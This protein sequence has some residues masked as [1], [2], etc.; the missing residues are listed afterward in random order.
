MKK[1]ISTVF[2]S[3]PE[4]EA[5]AMPSVYP[6]PQLVRDSFLSLDGKWEF[7]AIPKGFEPVFD[8]LITVPFPPESPLSRIGEVFPDGTELNYR[9]SFTLPDGFHRGR[10][11]LHFGAADQVA[12]IWLNSH[13]LG[14][15][16]GGYLP[17]SFDITA[18]LRP[19]QNDLFVRVTDDLG[20]HVLPWGKQKHK[21]GG[22]WYTPVSGLWQSVWL[23]SVPEVYI[24]SLSIQADS[25]GA[26][27]RADGISEGMIKVH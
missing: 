24:K 21:R 22:M 4:A 5:G 8:R 2:L 10:V 18:H 17:F 16:E 12:E 1:K 15:H 23:E 6:R 27:I 26:V 13:F 25:T 19:G 3:T 11:L 20:S 14:K 7:C 9:R